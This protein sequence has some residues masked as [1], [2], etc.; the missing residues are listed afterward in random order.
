MKKVTLILLILVLPLQAFAAME[1]NLTHILSGSG[2]EFVLKHITEHANLVMHH[3]DGDGLIVDD[4]ATHADHSQKSVQ[5]LA[6]YEHGYSMNILLPA[7]NQLGLVAIERIAPSFWPEVFS[8]RTT[9]P[10]LRPPRL[11]F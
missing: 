2:M 9:S 4:D 1:R 5:H 8:D 3:H 11:A 6:D 7:F 10:L